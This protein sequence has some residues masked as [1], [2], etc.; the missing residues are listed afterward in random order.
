[1]ENL[2][3]IERKKDWDGLKPE[4]E[5]MLA[6][7][8]DAFEVWLAEARAIS[9]DYSGRSKEGTYRRRYS[10]GDRGGKLFPVGH[11]NTQLRTSALTP[12]FPT[13]VFRRRFRDRDVP[14]RVASQ[15]WERL[16]SYD[17]EKDSVTHVMM[18][19]ILDLELSGRGVTWLSWQPEIEDGELVGAHVKWES[20]EFSHFYH[21]PYEN[22]DRLMRDG[23]IARK[24]L[25][26]ID[27]GV[28]RWGP[29]FANMPTVVPTNSRKTGSRDTDQG[30]QHVLQQVEVYEI[31]HAAAGPNGDEKKVYWFVRDAKGE[32][33][34]KGGVIEDR[35]D[36][37]GLPGFFP[38]ARPM[39]GVLG[40]D[41]LMPTPNSVFYAGLEDEVEKLSRKIDN[42]IPS[43]RSNLIANADIPE[44]QKGIESG[45]DNSV[46]YV[47][48]LSEKTGPGGVQAHAQ[49]VDSSVPQAVVGGLAQTRDITLG[50][51]DQVSGV[52]DLHRG[53]LKRQETLGQSNIRQNMGSLR[54][55]HDKSMIL[56][57]LREVIRLKARIIAKHMPQEMMRRNS[58][59][60]KMEEIQRLMTPDNPFA[61]EEM[62]Q[63]VYQMIQADEGWRIDLEIRETSELEEGAQQQAAIEMM[64]M[65]T[66]FLKEGAQASMFP[67]LAPVIL[68]MLGSTI[69]RFKLGRNVE[70]M[71]ED[72]IDKAERAEQEAQNQP[73]QPSPEEME[74]QVEIQKKQQEM[75]I[76][77]QEGQIK[78]QQMAAELEATMAKVRVELE[79]AEAKGL[80]QRQEAE[81]KSEEI[82]TDADLNRQKALVELTKIM[83]DDEINKLKAQVQ[84]RKVRESA[85]RKGNK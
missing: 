60:D 13:P 18:S 25:V 65:V 12:A 47:P 64:G 37:L 9:N 67:G 10:G 69:R 21:S 33:G 83:S 51:L 35:I 1:M 39:Y 48:Q 11:S 19:S 82:A 84:K 2:P 36:P 24:F 4:L 78:L 42:I 30:V 6:S 80:I 45:S 74:A 79:E 59:F 8:E 34:K 27:A 28:R 5:A 43:I 16:V 53:V 14:A 3:T 63:E 66:Q 75:Q 62:W 56:E 44:I 52:N 70:D 46:I 58:G 61:V 41:S 77:A 17:L 49:Y 68:R 71:I 54:M 76:K 23:W 29:E 73:P 40:N 81:A 22:W 50:S 38:V 55:I 15:V 85:Q 7:Y 20:V 26:G 31:W 57:H 32:D 72:L